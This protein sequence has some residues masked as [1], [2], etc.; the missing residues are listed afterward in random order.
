MVNGLDEKI[1]DNEEGRTSLSAG[2]QNPEKFEESNSGLPMIIGKMAVRNRRL[3]ELGISYMTGV[4]NKWKQEGLVLSNKRSVRVLAV[5]FNTSLF[6]DRLNVN[7]EVAK[8]LVDV[9]D[10]YSQ[11]YGKQQLGVFID[12]IGTLAKRRLFGWENAK[13][14]VGFRIEYADY[15]QGSFKET[16]G[17]IADDIWAIVPTIVFRPAGSTVLRFNYH[18]EQQRD[19]LGNAPERTGVI[20]LGFSSYF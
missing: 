3:G 14:N 9:P 2:K 16:N 4:Y 11:Q 5:D 20:Q 13:L 19:L 18:Y 1:I 7:G 6:R 17:N 8:V 12:V 10:T 15:N